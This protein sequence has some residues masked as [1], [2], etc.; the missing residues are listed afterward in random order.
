MKLIYQTDVSTIMWCHKHLHTMVYT[1]T[2]LTNQVDRKSQ[3]IIVS[4]K[5]KKATAQDHHYSKH[6]APKHK[7]QEKVTKATECYVTSIKHGTQVKKR[8]QQQIQWAYGS[9]WQP[10]KSEKRHQW[11]KILSDSTV[12]FY[13]LNLHCY[14]I[15]KIYM[16]LDVQNDSTVQQDNGVLT[17]ER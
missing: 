2:A 5:K 14:Q 1:S 6:V 15:C 7:L 3:Y 4:F 11:K 9:S 13:L 10:E 17:A 12:K 16:S 8:M